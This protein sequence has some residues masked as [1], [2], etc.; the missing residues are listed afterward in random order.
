MI[1]LFGLIAIGLFFVLDTA[2]VGAAQ[3]FLWC[4][5]RAFFYWLVL[6]KKDTYLCVIAG[7]FA[8][9]PTF[10]RTGIYGADLVC[11]IPLA[12]GLKYSARVAH[13]SYLV[14][15]FLVFICLL[16]HAGLIDCI[17]EGIPWQRLSLF[18][19]VFYALVSLGI[20]FLVS[21]R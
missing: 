9:M 21:K 11:M 13:L 7:F 12:V 2:A 8:L 4:F 15:A 3:L 5:N 18:V 16:V 19:L 10:I 6:N 14:K 17:W 1:A 20:G